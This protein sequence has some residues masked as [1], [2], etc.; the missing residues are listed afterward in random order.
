[1]LRDA[2]RRGSTRATA[3]SAAARSS[4]PAASRA[5]PGSELAELG[6]AGL[7]V[8]EAHGGMGLGPVEAMVVMEELGRGLV[9]EPF[10]AVALIATQPAQAGHA[11]A[12]RRR[13]LPRIAEGEALVVLAHQ[14][15]AVA[16]PPRPRR[17]ARRTAAATPGALS[18]RKSVVPAGDQADAFIVPAR[19]SG[20]GRRRGRHRAC[21]SSSAAQPGVDVRGYPTQDGAR[22]R[23]LVLKDAAGDRARRAPARPSPRSSTRS[24][25]ASPRSA[26][27]RSA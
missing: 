11:A 16:L 1:M 26:P 2:V 24:T 27:K 15:R 25:S 12:P 8:P 21:S 14:E 20:D 23:R 4:R 5:R 13:W 9:L 17:D 10:A 22:G 3:S 18:G 7:Y 19:V 6:L